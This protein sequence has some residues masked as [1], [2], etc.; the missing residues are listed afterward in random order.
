[1]DYVDL[2]PMVVIEQVRHADLASSENNDLFGWIEERSD[3]S[4]LLAA[5]LGIGDRLR[6]S[7][8]PQVVDDFCNMV[9]SYSDELMPEGGSRIKAA[10]TRMRYS[11]PIAQNYFAGLRKTG[12]DLRS[13]LEDVML[14]DWSFTNPRK[15]A[16]TWHYYMYLASLGEA[17]ALE[18]LGDKIASA[19]SGNQAA[20]LLESFS[21]LNAEGADELLRS[22]LTDTRETEDPEG[23]GPTVAENVETFLQLRSL[24]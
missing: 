7:S 9:A 16:H 5:I 12:I 21:D 3:V 23:P 4:C 17:G 10:Y 14:D 24:R 18:R 22:Y 13:R 19:S 20:N 15:K 1:M 6:A 2:C 8:D 11:N